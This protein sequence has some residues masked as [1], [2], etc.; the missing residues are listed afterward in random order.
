MPGVVT[1]VPEPVRAT[2]YWPG[3]TSAALLASGGVLVIAE[4][5][6]LLCFVGLGF[7]V[8]GLYGALRRPTRLRVGPASSGPPPL[9][10]SG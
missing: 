4:T 9:R 10:P 3:W 8:A 1:A 2:R 6:N 7:V 5:S